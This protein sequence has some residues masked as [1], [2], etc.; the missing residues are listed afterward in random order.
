[1]ELDRVEIAKRVC[2]ENSQSKR[3]SIDHVAG[4]GRQSAAPLA[5]AVDFC[6][7]LGGLSLAARQL[8]MEVVAG[9]DT[10]RDALR[11]FAQNF[12]GAKAIEATISG[13]TAIEKCKMAIRSCRHR[14]VPLVILSGPPCQGFSAAG[15]RDPKDKR[16]K[17]LLGVARAISSLQ[18]HCALVENV[19]ML[20]TDKHR[21][22]VRDFERHLHDAGYQ[23]LPVELNA[24]DYSVPQKRHRAFFLVTRKKLDQAAVIRRFESLK[25]PE[26]PCAVSLDDL[27]IAKVRGE[28]YS[29]AEDLLRPTTNHLAMRHSMAVRA[30]IA[31]I[32]AGCG[33]M[34]YRKLDPTKPANTLFSG[35]RAPPAHYKYPRSITVR[36]AARLQGFPDGFG[37]CGSFANQMMQVTNAVP[38]PLARIV[39]QVLAEFT[40]QSFRRD[41]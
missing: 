28:T 37:I 16:N 39:L 41:G 36:E 40:D 32:A 5:V 8:G 23:V 10:D 29:N 25:Q 35:H 18:P 34:S 24:K 1:M 22:R 33:P 2:D 15:S 31:T 12:P 27:P 30:K 19:Q 38:P 6:C 26:I 11:T 3:A 13:K 4:S 17:T 14:E 7:G 9:V 20:L 21:R